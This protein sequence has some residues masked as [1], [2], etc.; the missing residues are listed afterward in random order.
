M[1]KKLTIQ[2]AIEQGYT[3]C[4]IK[5][6]D[7]FQRLISLEHMDESNFEN[8]RKYVLADKQAKYY[9]NTSLQLTELLTEQVATWYCEESGDDDGM[10]IERELAKIIDLTPISNAINEYFTKHPFYSLTDIEV[11]LD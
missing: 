7:S 4:G 9:T 8:D 10:E 5:D 1:A 11:V 2:Q 3:S 6:Y